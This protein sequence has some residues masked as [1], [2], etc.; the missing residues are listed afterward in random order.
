MVLS[1]HTLSG[2]AGHVEPMEGLVG[3]YGHAFETGIVVARGLK[4]IEI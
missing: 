2:S 4:E 1:Y 3:V